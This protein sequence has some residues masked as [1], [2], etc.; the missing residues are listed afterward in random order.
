MEKNKKNKTKQNKIII[1][2][3]SRSWGCSGRAEK[4]KWGQTKIY[5]PVLSPRMPGDATDRM[6]EVPTLPLD[7]LMWKAP[8]LFSQTMGSAETVPPCLQA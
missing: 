7:P 3:R 6:L 4:N 2:N 1:K 5:D 8:C